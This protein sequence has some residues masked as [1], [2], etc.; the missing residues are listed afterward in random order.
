M[1]IDE[2]SKER[3]LSELKQLALEGS[4][5]LRHDPSQLGLDIDSVQHFNCKFGSN[6]IPEY[7]SLAA[8]LIDTFASTFITSPKFPEGSIRLRIVCGLCQFMPDPELGSPLFDDPGP[9]DEPRPEFDL[10]VNVFKSLH[11][12]A[13]FPFIA[14]RELMLHVLETA[15]YF[16]QDW[17]RNSDFLYSTDKL[18]FVDYPGRMRASAV[19]GLGEPLPDGR[20]NFPHSELEI[21]VDDKL[22]AKAHALL[23]FHHA[24]GEA[25]AN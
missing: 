22:R 11:G 3:V 5:D 15:Q 7:R 24:T 6:P 20:L 23:T 17:W 16:Q 25:P 2:D 4:L 19:P 8:Q 13:F 21:E 18:W 9:D 10:Y 14:D 12:N 1:P